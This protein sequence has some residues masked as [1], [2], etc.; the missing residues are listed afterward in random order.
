MIS[1]RLV[2]LAGVAGF[3]PDLDALLFWVFELLGF[4]IESYANHRM[5]FHNI[6]IPL[7]FFGFFVLMH[8]I[9]KR[10]EFGKVF[11]VIAFGFSIH[12]I[13][14]VIIIGYVMPFF[15]LSTAEVGLN[16][17][18]LIPLNPITIEDVTIPFSAAAML[19]LD[20]AL[21]LFWLWHEEMERH[22]LDY[23]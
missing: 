6:W 14:D 9:L 18:N 4:Q 20:A 23:F 13:L 2:F 22:I 16:L 1:N 12:L 8:F 10:K 7:F 15:P 11:L 17:A 3:V 19:A 21:L 5:F